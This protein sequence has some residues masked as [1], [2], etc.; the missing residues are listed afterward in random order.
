MDAHTSS[1]SSLVSAI[2][3]AQ[4]DQKSLMPGVRHAPRA[5]RSA[6]ACTAQVPIHADP[7]CSKMPH[8]PVCRSA[9]PRRL[10]MNRSPYRCLFGTG[11]LWHG[12]SLVR[13]LRKGTDAGSVGHAEGP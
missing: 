13:V 9:I 12:I 3:V 11:S 2:P 4:L 10:E 8:L 7:Q 6:L 5:E 1:G